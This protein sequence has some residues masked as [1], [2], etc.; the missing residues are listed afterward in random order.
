M[1][2][3][4]GRG[5]ELFMRKMRAPSRSVGDPRGSPGVACLGSVHVSDNN[6]AAGTLITARCARD[7]KVCSEPRCGCL[8]LVGHCGKSPPLLE[9]IND[10]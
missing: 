7:L 4:E 6:D 5:D 3:A 8:S 2:R 1:M 9:Q 10:D